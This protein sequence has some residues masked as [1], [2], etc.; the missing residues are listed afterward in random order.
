MYH[1]LRI[2][3]LLSIVGISGCGES[4]TQAGFNGPFP[5][6][7]VVALVNEG[8]IE[9]SLFLVG[10]L[11][12]KESIDIRS[13]IEAKVTYIGFQEGAFIQQGQ[14]LFK[15][16]D[17][18][19]KAQVA[20]AKARYELAKHDFE[21]GKTLL[22]KETIS[23]QQFDQFRFTQDEAQAALR[24]SQERMSEAIITAPF[25]GRMDE[26][27]VSLGQFVNVGELLSS[28]VQVNPLEVEFNVPERYLGQLQI[29][30]TIKI[31][32]VAYPGED[33]RGKVIFISPKLDERNR[34]VLM[35]AE[36]ENAD[37]RLKPGMFANLE[38]IFRAREDAIVIPEQSI[39]FQ[40]DQAS[41]VVMDSEGK[42]E[43]RNVEVGLR[44]SGMAEI[45]SGLVPGERIVVEG[46]QKMAPGSQIVISPKS[47]QYGVVSPTG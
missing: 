33:F 46:F 26:R 21:R 17:E 7:A 34:T 28:L 20:E 30:Q 19:L 27:K 18:K 24:L 47:E 39:S 40:A 4:T 31:S 13:E 22:E 15:L 29:G 16:D 3:L 12:A 37:G 43:F 11:A 14:E 32:S 41:V 25:S 36:M 2:V 9:E 35:K 42:A 10:N 44:L 6:R 23:Q 5:V 8:N 38:L 45:I 1:I